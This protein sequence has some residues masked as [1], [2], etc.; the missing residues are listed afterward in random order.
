MAAQFRPSSP[1]FAQTHSFELAGRANARWIGRAKSYQ[2]PGGPTKQRMGALA[3][4]F[5]FSTPRCSRMQFI[6][7]FFQAEVILVQH[8]SGACDIGESSVL[9]FHSNSGRNRDTFG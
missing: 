2:L 3:F 1:G 8:L 5:S 9:V 7:T 4:G 6:F